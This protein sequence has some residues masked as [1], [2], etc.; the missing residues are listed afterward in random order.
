MHEE[1]IEAADKQRVVEAI[2]KVEAL[3]KYLEKQNVRLSVYDNR[4]FLVTYHSPMSRKKYQC[5]YRMKQK[6]F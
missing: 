6:D 3:L 4:D 5:G 2:E 1:E